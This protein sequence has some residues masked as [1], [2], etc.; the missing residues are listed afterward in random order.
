MTD[1]NTELRN[2]ITALESEK[3]GMSNMNVDRERINSDIRSLAAQL[4]PKPSLKTHLTGFAVGVATAVVPQ[5][6]LVY[7]FQIKVLC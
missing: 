7:V 2:R 6:L 4:E 5:L 3:H 1:R